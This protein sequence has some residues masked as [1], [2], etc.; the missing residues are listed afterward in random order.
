MGSTIGF[1]ASTRQKIQVLYITSGDQSLLLPVFHHPSRQPMTLLIQRPIPFHTSRRPAAESHPR[2]C[3]LASPGEVQ[4]V[5]QFYPPSSLACRH[6]PVPP[7]TV[8]EAYRRSLRWE[9]Y[10]NRLTDL[11]S[12]PDDVVLRKHAVDDVHPVIAIDIGVIDQ[13]PK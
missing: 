10:P 8:Y 7:T 12:S 2:R 4:Q 5:T 9:R 6:P 11:L 1:K 3:S 13:V